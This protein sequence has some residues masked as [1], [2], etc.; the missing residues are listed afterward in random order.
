ML[1]ENSEIGLSIGINNLSLKQSA[2]SSFERFNTPNLRQTNS[3]FLSTFFSEELHIHI[4]KQLYTL[5]IR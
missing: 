3:S 5:I 1:L 2:F 4:H